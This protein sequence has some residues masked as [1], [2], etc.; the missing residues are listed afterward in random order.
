[1]DL[2]P[3]VIQ[4]LRHLSI[5][6]WLQQFWM[7]CVPRAKQRLGSGRGW[8]AGGFTYRGQSLARMWVQ[9][10]RVREDWRSEDTQSKLA[11]NSKLWQ[12]GS[13]WRPIDEESGKVGHAVS[14]AQSNRR[15]SHLSFS[16]RL[17][18]CPLVSPD[19]CMWE[20]LLGS[21]CR[22]EGKGGRLQVPLLRPGPMLASSYMLFLILK[23][24]LKR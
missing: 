7:Y 6:P 24:I 8:Q 22:T 18:V 14:L 5:H 10:L 19:S 21:A 15:G 2:G 11:I 23:Y 13:A 12:L 17:A 9:S 4:N 3:E 1:M 20:F 16:H